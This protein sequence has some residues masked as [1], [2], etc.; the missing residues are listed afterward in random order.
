M[1]QVK[2]IS[3]KNKWE[4]SSENELEEAF[5]LTFSSKQRGQ[6]YKTK[7]INVLVENVVINMIV[8]S[9]SSV[10]LIDKN[11]F[12][13]IKNHSPNLL[14]KKSS[15]VIFPYAS[16]SLKLIGCLKA[17]IETKNKITTNK[18][19]VVNK[20][21]VGNIMGI[22]T[23]KELN[24]LKIDANENFVLNKDNGVSSLAKSNK[25]M[26]HF[27]VCKNI[28]DE[29]KSPLNQKVNNLQYFDAN[30]KSIQPIAQNLR[31]YPYLLRKDIRAKLRRLEEVDIIEKVEGPRE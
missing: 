31:R 27:N 12:E 18:I 17:E 19:Y 10:N 6:S 28:D 25:T 15:T 5:A 1:Q 13:R 3:N 8:D 2:E 16:T 21:N 24:I 9:D 26:Q 30:Y 4:S 14:L 20:N 23:A 7:L 11:T 22:E 29:I